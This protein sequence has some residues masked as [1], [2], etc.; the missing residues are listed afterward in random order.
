MIPSILATLFQ[1]IVPLSIPVVAGI[2]L[3][4]FKQLD[5]KHVLTIVLYFLM[6]VMIFKTLT[7]SQ[8]S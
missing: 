6:P 8:I 2:L 1:V 3:V 5:T 4:R 7:S